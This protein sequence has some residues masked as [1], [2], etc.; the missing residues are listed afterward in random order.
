MTF[1][2]L[3]WAT[4]TGIPAGRRETTTE[5]EGLRGGL[6]ALDRNAW[7]AVVEPDAVLESLEIELRAAGFTLGPL[8]E[9]A[10]FLSVA[11]AL[12]TDASSLAG[13][14]AGFARRRYD[15]TPAGIRLRVQPAPEVQAGLAAVLPG[16]AQ[17]LDALRD[18]ARGH[19]APAEVI[20]LDAAATR[21]WFDAAEIGEATTDLLG[22][23]DAVLLMIAQGPAGV[24]SERLHRA[25][26][27]IADHHA[28]ALAPEVARAWSA[29]RD[30]IARAV[31]TLAAG[32][33][34]LERREVRRTWADAVVEPRRAG[35]WVGV[36]ATGIDEQSLVVR[37]RRLS[38]IP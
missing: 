17:G 26:A 25:A 34:R 36:E 7:L 19:D 6:A 37:A 20:L 11:A 16:F 14:G 27:A 35:V 23:D 38:A 29:A 5:P 18:L 13:S 21:L 15:E 1:D 4:L 30:R 31:P 33:W 10:P 8:P 28:E 9:D 22:P 2:P 3:R 12:A 24:A 32:G